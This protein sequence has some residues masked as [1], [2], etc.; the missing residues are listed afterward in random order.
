MR[1]PMFIPI[2]RHV[3]N[4]TPGTATLA[5][6]ISIII[7]LIIFFVGLYIFQRKVISFYKNNRF[8]L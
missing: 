4:V 3:S 5:D 8:K 6:Y 7:A 1:F 2:Y